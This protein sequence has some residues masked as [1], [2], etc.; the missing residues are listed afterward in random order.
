M[1]Y[2]KEKDGVIVNNEEGEKIGEI[3]IKDY[4]DG[5]KEA[6]TTKV[7]KEYGGRGIARNLVNHLVEIAREEDFKIYP[8]CS[9]A[10]K[11]LNEDYPEL[12]YED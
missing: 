8:T 4:K 11:V 1:E 6:Y 3:R 12:V 5:V 2:I 9:Y 7:K 10:D